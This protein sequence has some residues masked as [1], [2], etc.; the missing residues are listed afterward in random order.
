MRSALMIV[1]ETRCLRSDEVNI[2]ISFFT[3]AAKA[4]VG[5]ASRYPCNVDARY[6]AMNEANVLLDIYYMNLTVNQLPLKSF[7]LHVTAQL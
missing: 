6:S 4:Q 5:F 2:W 7:S 3:Y 1:R